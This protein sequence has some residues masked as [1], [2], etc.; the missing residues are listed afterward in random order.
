MWNRR[1]S[2][3][4]DRVSALIRAAEGKRLMYRCPAE[5][6][7]LT[8]DIPLDEALRRISHGEVAARWHSR[9]THAA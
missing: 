3:D 8:I 7:R 2:S 9:P 4:G 5:P 1:K 6:E